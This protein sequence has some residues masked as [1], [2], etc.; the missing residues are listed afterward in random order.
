MGAVREN[1]T[2]RNSASVDEHAMISGQAA[3]LDSSV[4]RGNAVISDQVILAGNSRIQGC[5][6]VCGEG[7]IS[8]F[9]CDCGT[10]QFPISDTDIHPQ[11]PID[12]QKGQEELYRLK[13]VGFCRNEQEAQ[14]LQDW[15]RSH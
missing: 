6:Y 7:T 9:I 5:A 13:E 3:I 15:L 8:D 4:V 1:A 14:L 2:V 11:I 12:P 10:Y